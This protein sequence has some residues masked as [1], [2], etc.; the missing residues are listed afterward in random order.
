MERRTVDFNASD[1]PIQLILEG[2]GAS[3][4]AVLIGTARLQAGQRIPPEGESTHPAD[5]YS[6]VLRGWAR[7]TVGGQE[8][9]CGPG[10]LL[11]TPAGEGHVTLGLEDTEVLWWWAGQPTDFTDLKA[12]YADLS[13]S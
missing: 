13:T 1:S 5:E 10:T 9:D 6:Y 11:L 3:S 8:M 7:V 12:Q 2:N 4:A